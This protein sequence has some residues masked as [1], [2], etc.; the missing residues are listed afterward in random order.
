M[1]TMIRCFVAWLRRK[2]L[3]V[4]SGGKRDIGFG[5]DAYD[6]RDMYDPKLFR[7]PK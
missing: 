3:Q 2:R 6:V 1:K 7:R 4:F 5:R